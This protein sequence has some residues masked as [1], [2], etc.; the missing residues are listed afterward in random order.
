MTSGKEKLISALLNC[1]Q[2]TGSQEPNAEKMRYMKEALPELDENESRELIIRLLK[3]CQY[4][5]TIAEIMDEWR[6]MR[7]CSRPV[8]F[9]AKRVEKPVFNPKVA[10]LLQETKAAIREGR[11]VAGVVIDEKLMTFARGYFPGIS[12]A[13]MQRNALELSCCYQ[14]Q[15]REIE[16]NS[17]YRTV[18]V[19]DEDGVISS[20]M[21]R[22]V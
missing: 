6:T 9:T 10:R 16:A 17:R 19:M 22:I 21:R 12:L 18:P 13:T 5:P 2:K 7:R 8:V 20:W 4:E 11:P 3:R 1:F 15:L 14:E